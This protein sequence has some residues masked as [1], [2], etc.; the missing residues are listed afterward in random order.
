MKVKINILLDVG[1]LVLY[2]W[3]RGGGGRPKSA[4]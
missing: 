4:F 3:K 2:L 1:L